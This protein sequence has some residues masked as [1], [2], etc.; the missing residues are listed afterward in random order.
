VPAV[1]AV[2]RGRYCLYSSF[3]MMHCCTL[4]LTFRCTVILP[5]CPPTLSSPPPTCAR[6][7][8]PGPFPLCRAAP[9]ARRPA[10]AVPRGQPGLAGM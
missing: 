10:A 2:R 7:L 9:A 6:K 3:L 1:R 8:P 5:G 4:E